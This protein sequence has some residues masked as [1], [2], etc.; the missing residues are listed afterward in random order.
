MKKIMS[1]LLISVLLVFPVLSACSNKSGAANFPSKP[2]ELIV[3]FAAGGGT[4]TIG[5]ALAE[6]MKASLGQEVVVANKTGGSGSVGMNEGLHAQPDGYTLTMVTREVASLPMMG[7][8]PFKTDDF[9]YIGNVNTDHIVLVVSAKSKYRTFEDLMAALKANPGK[10]NF[11]ASAVPNYYAIPFAQ[12]AKADFVTVPFQGAAPAIVEILGGRADF[13]LYGPGEVKTHIDSGNLRPLAIMSDQRLEGLKDVPTM[14]EKG[15]DVIAM[16]Y[17][18][19]AVPKKTP[20]EIVKKLETA[21]AKAVK[22]PKFI[23]FMNQS[24][25]E[26]DYKNAAD[27]KAYIDN[28]TKALVPIVEAAKKQQKP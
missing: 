28:D 27:F 19:L 18:G 10:L 24:F 16:T 14:K 25:A 2:I 3:P 8:A 11:A 20:D 1:W 6:A 9:T 22:D 13:G 21:V 17:R 12:A 26:I 23:D 7:L 4:D 5:R 15:V